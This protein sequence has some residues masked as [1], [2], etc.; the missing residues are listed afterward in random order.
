MTPPAETSPASLPWEGTGAPACD[1][2]VRDSWQ[3]VA[4]QLMV[5][6]GAAISPRRPGLLAQLLLAQRHQVAVPRT[7]VTT[8][9]SR[10]HA[11]F[12]CSRLVLKAVDRHFVEAAPG[13][14]SGVFP[15]IVARHVGASGP[16]PGPPVIVQEFVE[17]EAELRV[18]YVHGDVHVFEIGKDSPAAL[19]EGSGQVSVR[20]V[21]PPPAVV[22]ATRLLAAAMSLT[23]G[24][25][26]F[27]VRNGMPVFLEVNPD[28]DWR[29]AEQK[30]RTM[31]VTL[32][33][34][35][36]LAELDREL[37]PGNDTRSFDL[38]TFLSRKYGP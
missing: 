7:M 29:W 26:D 31:A 20:S 11:A 2:F 6:S 16:C 4:D 34:A 33:V 13:R 36:M 32:A 35:R 19:W 12:R 3:A 23:Y 17:H 21:V 9:P 22:A 30:A 1:M 18:Y 14:L 37:Q 5:I 24:A 8:D 28:G 15:A 10:A 38:L 27:L 25:F